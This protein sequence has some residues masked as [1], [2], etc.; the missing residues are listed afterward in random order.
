MRIDRFDRAILDALQKDGASTSA[1][2]AEIVHFPPP[3]A[4]GDV[5]RW[6]RPASSK[7][8]RRA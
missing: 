1:A 8:I 5:R 6:K 2:L 4:P 3:S 7:A